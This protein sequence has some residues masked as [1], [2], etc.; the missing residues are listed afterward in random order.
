LF[1]EIV[2]GEI[3]LPV[4]LRTDGLTPRRSCL[5]PADNVSSPDP[6]RRAL[7]GSDGDGLPI[8]PHHCQRLNVRPRAC[9]PPTPDPIPGDPCGDGAHAFPPVRAAM[10]R[11]LMARMI[12]AAALT[13]DHWAS[14]TLIA[15]GV[16]SAFGM[17]AVR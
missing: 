12:G 7:I 2:D 1:E 14:V 3:E 6:E 11:A 8:D 17:S 4:A 13:A 5:V 15:S 10:L 9:V 16:I